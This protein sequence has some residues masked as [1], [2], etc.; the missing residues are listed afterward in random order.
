MEV[1]LNI[2]NLKHEL[3]KLQKVNFVSQISSIVLFLV[4]F[5]LYFIDG[6][7]TINPTFILVNIT[8]VIFIILSYK[9]SQK[10]KFKKIQI[11]HFQNKG[12]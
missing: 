11:K 12:K 7:I 1:V 6:K 8:N 10:I 2:D 4:P 9:L 3:K 5:Y